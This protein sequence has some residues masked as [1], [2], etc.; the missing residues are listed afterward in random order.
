SDPGSRL[1][2][3]GQHKDDAHSEELRALAARDPR[4]RLVLTPENVP[5]E[6]VASWLAACDC[7]AAPYRD[8]Y[9]SGVV[10]LAATF[11]KPVA[12]RRLGIFRSLGNPGFGR[13]FE[14]GD[15][16][17]VAVALEAVRASDP[18]ELRDS[19]L[20]FSGDHDWGRITAEVAAILAGR[21]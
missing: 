7:V 6:S 11:R 21:L 9:T 2:V 19:A 18:G 12:A 17:A 10:Y 4:I 8:V 16:A 5:D 1:F 15:E 3:V 14:P 13:P 20:R